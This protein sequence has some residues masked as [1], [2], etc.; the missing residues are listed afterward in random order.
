MA[1]YWR[2]TSQSVLLGTA[3]PY[4]NCECMNIMCKLYISWPIS[5]VCV[6]VC[7]SVWYHSSTNIA[8]FYAQSGF[9]LV[10]SSLLI[11][12]FLINPSVQKL[13]REEA[14]MQISMYSTR[15]KKLPINGPFNGATV[16]VQIPFKTRTNP[17]RVSRSQRPVL[18]PVLT[19]VQTAVS[20]LYFILTCVIVTAQLALNSARSAVRACSTVALA[21]STARMQ[22]LILFDSYKGHRASTMAR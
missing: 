3:A 12:G 6:C 17:V 2:G 15:Q 19:A 21:T 22:K 18:I 11:G 13:W 10:F 14:N 4:I 7:L 1:Y 16:P 5:C 9:I 20:C 8:C